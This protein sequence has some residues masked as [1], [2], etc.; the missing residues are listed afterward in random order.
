MKEPEQLTMM[1]EAWWSVIMS[2]CGKSAIADR[3]IELAELNG[4]FDPFKVAAENIV[5]GQSTLKEK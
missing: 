5:D 2:A 4:L 3:A 1:R